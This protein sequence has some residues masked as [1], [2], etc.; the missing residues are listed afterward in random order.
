MM[1]MWASKPVISSL[2]RRGLLWVFLF[3]GG[4]V[5]AQPVNDACSGAIF[6]SDVTNWCSD[7]GAYTTIDATPSGLVPASCMTGSQRDVWFAF[8]AE[9]TDA[10]IV[11]NGNS[12]IGAGGTMFDPRMALYSSSTGDCSGTLTELECAFG[13]GVH[14]IEIYFGGLT[15]GETYFIRAS[16]FSPNGG[17]FQMCINNYN[18]IPEPNS[19]C[20][21]GVILCDKSSFNVEAL[22]GFGLIDEDLGADPCLST[23]SSSVWYKWTCKDA[24]TL[25]FTLTPNNPTDD[26]DF[27][28]YELPNG[29]YDCTDKITLRCM[30]SGENVGQP[31]PN[32]EPCTG[33]TGLNLASTDTEELPGCQ[34][35]DDNFIAAL[36]MEV[37]KSY[38]LIINNFSNTG[39]GF[40]ITF[41]GTGTFVGPEAEFITLPP[42]PTYCIAEP[43]AFQDIS[44]YSLGTIIGQSWF[45]GLDA[46]PATASGPGP[47]SV[48]YGSEG[49]K[50]I[51]LVIE[52]DQGCQVTALQE[53]VIETCCD[54]LNAMQIEDTLSHLDC[55]G[56]S[57]GTIDLTVTSIT[58]VG[59][60]WDNGSVMP[61][62]AGLPAGSYTVTITNEATCDTVL[63]YEI[64]SP[65]EILGHPQV[66]MPTCDGGQDGAIVLQTE[67]GVPPY[68]YDWQDGM[69]FVSD[70]THTNL[71]A[72][73]YV[74]TI[75]D[76]ND[77][78][79]TLAVDVRELELALN[80]AVE[81]IT[82]PSCH[83]ASD[84]SIILQVINGLPPYSFNFNGTGW[85]S[86]T[87]YGGLP[88]GT[89]YVEALD[90][91]NCRGYFTFTVG[92]PDSLVVTLTGTD[93]SCFG[94]LDGAI[95]SEVEGGTA[96]YTYQWSNGFSGPGLT[97]LPPGSY[98]VTVI[99]ARGCTATASIDL[100]QPPELFIW[101][102]EVMD[103]RC[104][105][106]ANGQLSVSASGGTPGFQFS[107]DGGP[108]QDEPDFGGLKAGIYTVT[109]RDEAGCTAERMV[110]VNQPPPL[111]VDA[112]PDVTIELGETT[113]LHAVVS[114]P[115]TPV[116]YLWNPGE[117]LD[118]AD[119]PEVTSSAVNTTTYTVTVED[120]AGCTATDQV[121]VVVL[122]IRDIYIPNAF[123]PDFNGINDLFTIY[124]GKAAEAILV[125]RIYNRWG[126]LVYEG[127]LLP[128][129]DDS[130]GWDGTFNG[131]PLDPEVFAFYALIRFLDGEEIIYKGDI[132]LIR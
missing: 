32:W 106:E 67:G 123:S 71:S 1:W 38:A 125:L 74:V 58:T 99:D 91:N 10:T 77:C 50:T 75:R 107:L 41:G 3:A 13:N 47:H 62:Q 93:I 21:T 22:A 73:L 68:L 90:A 103:V 130:T 102:E 79:V 87:T 34:A 12:G 112:G 57:D 43:I 23:E 111:L 101:E 120:E 4:K 64:T 40:S 15:I 124:G 45:F 78:E 31:F 131:R 29:V 100:T 122:K 51:A 37:G 2:L 126:G 89:Y 59:F 19:D 119:C 44:S 27:V 104:Y 55:Y 25:T 70:P 18:A 109:V 85:S 61:D 110:T 48:K 5:C 42:Q 30:A 84:G 121:T 20:P 60:M 26:L 88:A 65:P 9:A 39:N 8:T 116:T 63:T 96:P 115:F 53:V 80:P 52:T 83:G 72:G 46:Q 69:G 127:E 54:G 113:L 132:Q 49:T 92:Q 56:D 76:A 94:L 117:S 66:T 105:G 16:A 7:F 14:V 108:F 129:N 118:C 95:A 6:L 128:L 35:G 81:A 97:G 28:V 33:P 36:D 82:E 86:N 98:S 17:T 24:G 11:L 114:P